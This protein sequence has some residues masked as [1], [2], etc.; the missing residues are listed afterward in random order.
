MTV[1]NY[2]VENTARINAVAQVENGG[3]L[4]LKN[5]SLRTKEGAKLPIHLDYV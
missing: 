3:N 2:H 4:I 5:G 1:E